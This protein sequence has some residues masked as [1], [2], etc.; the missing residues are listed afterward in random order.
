MFY[1][2]SVRQPSGIPSSWLACCINVVELN[3]GSI[4]GDL[5]IARG[6]STP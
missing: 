4:Y 2:F 5:V 3:A 1:S 6:K